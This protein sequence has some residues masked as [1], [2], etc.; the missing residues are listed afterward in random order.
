MIN[1]GIPLIERSYPYKAHFGNLIEEWAKKTGLVSI[2]YKSRLECVPCLPTFE[3]LNP[4]DNPVKVGENL[5]GCK[6]MK[7][8]CY[9]LLLQGYTLWPLASPTKT[10]VLKRLDSNCNGSCS[11][12]S[13]LSAIRKHENQPKHSPIFSFP[14]LT[15]TALAWNR[16]PLVKHYL[17]WVSTPPRKGKPCTYIL[18]GYASF[19]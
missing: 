7:K 6:K 9:S 17:E 10:H 18:I 16:F 3:P 8:L 13:L 2:S 5:Y 11:N 19:K 15:T 14:P 4:L 12:K 1:G